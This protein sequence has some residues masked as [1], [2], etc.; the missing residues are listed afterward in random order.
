MVSP[1]GEGEEVRG[2]GGG[3][4]GSIIMMS[5]KGLV[6]LFVCLFCFVGFVF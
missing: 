2:G 3:K 4:G 5:P 1:F 6:F